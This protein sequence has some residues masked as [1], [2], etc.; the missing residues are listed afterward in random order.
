MDFERFVTTLVRR[1]LWF[2]KAAK[3]HDD[4]WEGF[5]KVIAPNATALPEKLEDGTFRIE[6]PNQM[7]A[8]LRAVTQGSLSRRAITCM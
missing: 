2:T 3:F 1:S 7:Q 4:P 5:C 6:G 8:C